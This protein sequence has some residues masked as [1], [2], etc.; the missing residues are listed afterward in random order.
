MMIAMVGLSIS[1]MP[2]SASAMQLNGKMK[3]TG[4]HE[5]SSFWNGVIQINRQPLISTG[6]R[7]LFNAL[8]FPFSFYS[9]LSLVISI[10]SVYVNPELL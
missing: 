6:C 7:L 4:G 5:I 10:L 1:M 2:F 9:M 8:T 3:M